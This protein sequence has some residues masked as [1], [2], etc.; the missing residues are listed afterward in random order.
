MPSYSPA[1]KATA[2]KA[3]TMR[4]REE[5]KFLYMNYSCVTTVLFAYVY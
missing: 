5:I 4:V 3:Q 1:A 2:V